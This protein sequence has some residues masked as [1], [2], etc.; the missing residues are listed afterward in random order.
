M[1]AMELARGHV[2]DR[3]WGQTLGALGMRNLSGQLTLQSDDGN[4]YCIAFYSGAV[5][6]ATSPLATDSAA[7]IAVTN[8]LMLANQIGLLG[9]AQVAHPELDEFE[10]IARTCGM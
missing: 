10:L 2:T 9:R 3:P 1:D 8:H 6:G 5:I 4:Q 7:R